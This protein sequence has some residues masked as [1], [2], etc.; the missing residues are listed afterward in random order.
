MGSRL[1]NFN[2]QTS[3][4]QKVAPVDKLASPA[5]KSFSEIKSNEWEKSKLSNY[6]SLKKSD[7]RSQRIANYLDKARETYNDWESMFKQ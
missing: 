6:E 3:T 1:T 4:I 2:V 7:V 5:A